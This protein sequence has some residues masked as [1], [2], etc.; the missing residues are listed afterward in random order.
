M[1]TIRRRLGLGL[2]VAVI[3]SLCLG[4][5]APAMT[6]HDGWPKIDGMLLMNKLDQNRP[7]D[8]RVGQ[9]PFD[10]QDAAY[11]CDG[12][13]KSQKCLHQNAVCAGQ[14]DRHGRCSG[15]TMKATTHHN[16]LLGAHGNDAIHAGDN[17]DVIWGDYKE[18]SAQPS[19]QHDEL[20]GGAGPDFIYA[21]HGTNTI[22][23]GAGKDYVKAHFGRGSVDCGP[24]QDI[25]YIS[26]R[27]Q[28]NY[29]ITGCE[30]ISHKT[31]GY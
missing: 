1:L 8:A 2:L 18:E 16:E 17:G 13:H 29:D 23:A 7:M 10:S 28:K 20:S 15:W 9:D 31:K 24:G 11:R 14:P 3:A 22:A 25:L 21:S 6:S 26:R 19:S 5:S 12:L 4:T 30:T 27:A